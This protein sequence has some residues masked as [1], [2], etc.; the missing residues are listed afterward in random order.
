[1]LAPTW[2]TTA[3]HA[4]EF[5]P[6]RETRMPIFV[7]IV[8]IFMVG[9]AMKVFDAVGGWPGVFLI[10]GGLVGGGYALAIALKRSDEI[11]ALKAKPDRVSSLL[12]PAKALSAADPEA[13]FSDTLAE[14]EAGRA[15][16]FWEN[17]D[18]CC[19]GL[20]TVVDG[21]DRAREE[22]DAYK[23]GARKYK[24]F[25]SEIELGDAEQM[26][27]EVADV[28]RRTLIRIRDDALI[29]PAFA[30]I[31]EQRRQGQEIRAQQEAIRL[32]I[33][34]VGE[35]AQAALSAAEEASDDARR[36]H[37]AARRRW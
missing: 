7:G 36:A 2:S 16:L 25:P 10:V 6:I 3:R 5:T 34:V 1:M 9:V 28:Y 14:L 15:P 22:A 12:E 20:W 29:N 19:E 32:D 26:Y 27:R 30:M 37:G 4:L 24:L 31:Y 8:V 35:T 11:K 33:A 13:L 18:G 17:F 21:L 23:E